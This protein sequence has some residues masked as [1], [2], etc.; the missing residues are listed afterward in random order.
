MYELSALEA[1]EGGLWR[2]VTAQG[3]SLKE[4]RLA[5]SY[6]VMA[7]NSEALL[8]GMKLEENA[9]LLCIGI[10]VRCSL[11]LFTRT[12]HMASLS[13]KLFTTGIFLKL[14]KD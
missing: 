8:H 12:S 7:L 2:T 9:R 3:V 4:Y 1:Y 14:S 11:R 10:T 6:S 5:R 13:S